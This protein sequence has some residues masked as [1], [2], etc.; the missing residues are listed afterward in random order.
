MSL[1]WS[2]TVKVWTMEVVREKEEI[3]LFTSTC[4]QQEIYNKSMGDTDQMDHWCHL[5]VHPLV[6]WAK[7]CTLVVSRFAIKSGIGH[8]LLSSLRPVSIICGCCT[9]LGSYR[10]PLITC[11]WLVSSDNISPKRIWRRMG[12][13]ELSPTRNR[14][15]ST[16][17]LGWLPVLVILWDTTS[18]AMG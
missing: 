10:R 12:W 17:S 11:R 5:S 9:G 6:H 13:Q 7:G 2:Q 1:Q 18:M 15:Y 4:T 3:H 8:L 14:M 16:N